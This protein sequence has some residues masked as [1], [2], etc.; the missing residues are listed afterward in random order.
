MSG[1]AHDG[2]DTG[3][4]LDVTDLSVYFPGRRRQA[5]VRAVDGVSF[6]IARGE[7]LGLIGESG[8]GKSTV[9]KAVVGLIRPRAG[10]VSLK[11]VE[12]RRLS[13]REKRLHEQAVQIVFQ[14]PSEALDPRMTITASIGEPLRRR[15]LRGSRDEREERVR[16]VLERV[17]LDAAYGRRHPHEL[18]G[19]QRQRVNI[20]RA[21]VSQPELVICD[22]AVSALDVS[23]QAGIL[24][25]LAE[26]KAEQDLSY[27]F[28][29]HDLGVVAN[30]ADR[31]T[32][33]YLGRVI[34]TAV[35]EN[36]INRPA[37]PYTHALL[38]AEPQALP[39]RLRRQGRDVLKGDIPSPA[40]PPSGCRFRTRCRYAEKR[41][42]AE[43][44]QFRQLTP[45][46]WVACHFAEDIGRSR[47]ASGLDHTRTIPENRRT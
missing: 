32:V 18:S 36:I 40:D 37:H 2:F 8:S 29:S 24:N 41:C 19:G 22:E 16:E 30:V 9:G 45:G 38:A 21:L 10:S 20:A 5:P 12:T 31:I 42:A 1:T 47:A 14:D 17:G 35:T 46:H 3:R 43:E 7:T 13:R 26:L 23:V 4:L 33:M 15:A 27:L 39:R 28:I 34:E 44:P 6:S 11:G 25:L